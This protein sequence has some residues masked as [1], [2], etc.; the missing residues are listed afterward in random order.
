MTPAPLATQS[1]YKVPDVDDHSLT[2]PLSLFTNGWIHAVEDSELVL[3]LIAAR[4]RHLHGETLQPLPS[5]P[6]K[7]NSA[8][9]PGTLRV[10]PPNPGLPRDSRRHRRLQSLVGRQARRHPGAW[11]AAPRLR[12]RPEELDRP[13]DPT[14][15]DT[16]ANQIAKSEST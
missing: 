1:Q 12:L 6:R 13:A 2:V 14:I 16:I 15:I 3:V 5:G 4:M 10:S 9:S 8:S 11:S 7:L